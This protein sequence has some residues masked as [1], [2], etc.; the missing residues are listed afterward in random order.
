MTITLTQQLIILSYFILCG[1][2]IGVV[3]DIFR[4]LR[5]IIKTG[6]IL[7]ALEDLLFC[8]ISILVFIFFAIKFNLGIIRW[9]MFFSIMFGFIVYYYTLSKLIIKIST[10]IINLIKKPFIFTLNIS[11]MGIN[12]IAT[13]MKPYKNF[14]KQKLLLKKK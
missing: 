3:F 5:V 6:V 10:I 11:K 1:A 4:I 13:L 12:M 8:I 9:Y 2:I 14:C 7:T